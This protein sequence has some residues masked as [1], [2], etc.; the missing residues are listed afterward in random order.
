MVGELIKKEMFNH[1]WAPKKK[2]LPCDPNVISSCAKI[3]ICFWKVSHL[4]LQ[5][6]LLLHL[7]IRRYER[8][9][10]KLRGVEGEQQGRRRIGRTRMRRTRRKEE[11]GDNRREERN[12]GKTVG[13]AE[14]EKENEELSFAPTDNVPVW[15]VRLSSRS[16]TPR[17]P[18]SFP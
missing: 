18:S 15:S 3:L 17:L 16:P 10:E 12:R 14:G 11:E 8:D 7:C 4:W 9:E 1:L 2:N 6:D 5:G 13:A